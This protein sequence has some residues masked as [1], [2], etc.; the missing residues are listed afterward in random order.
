MRNIGR[1]IGRLVQRN[2]R[3]LHGWN[4]RGKHTRICRWLEK[5]SNWATVRLLC[6][7]GGWNGD[8]LLRW[9]RVRSVRWFAGW[10]RR[11]EDGWF[12]RRLN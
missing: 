9:A 12:T 8:W 6:W 4:K 3:G 1:M 11:R 10:L 5:R 2:P 7:Y